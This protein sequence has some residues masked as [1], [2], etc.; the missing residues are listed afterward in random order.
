MISDHDWQA[1][2]TGFP[3]LRSDRY[4]EQ[5]VKSNGVVRRVDEGKILYRDGDACTHLPLVISGE[6]ILTK[7]GESGR[8]ITLYRVE[9]G[10]SCIL[11]TLSIINDEAFPAEAASRGPSTLLLVPAG[12]LRQLIDRDD[13]WRNYVFSIYHRRLSGLIRLIEEVVFGKL[14]LRLAERLLE[15][16]AG[17]GLIVHTSHQ[18]LAEELGSSREVVSRLLKDWERR[19][20]VELRRGHVD[21]QDHRRLKNIAGSVT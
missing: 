8:A 1:F 21:I 18:E 4:S 10:E 20:L 9:D 2:V 17:D 11:S 14:D 6:L 16:A 15:R 13:S 12:I 7:H 3:V 19:G 5:L